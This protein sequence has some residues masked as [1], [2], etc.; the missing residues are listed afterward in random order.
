MSAAA[1]ALGSVMI[2]DSAVSASYEG[3]LDAER[4][5]QIAG[6]A[7]AEIVNFPAQRRVSPVTLVARNTSVPPPSEHYISLDLE[8]FQ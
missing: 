5:R 2:V 7:V 1:R 4:E 8:D 3:T 6:R